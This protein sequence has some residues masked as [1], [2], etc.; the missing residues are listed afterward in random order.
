MASIQC[1]GI[2][3]KGFVNVK[4][5]D[6]HSFKG[7]SLTLYRIECCSLEFGIIWLENKVQLLKQMFPGS[8]DCRSFLSNSGDSDGSSSTPYISEDND[9]MQFQKFATSH[10]DLHNIQCGIG[11]IKKTSTVD[12]GVSEVSM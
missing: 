6:L 5:I 12:L 11:S 2:E 4:W 7:R 3:L 8:T 10:S 1:Y 9:G